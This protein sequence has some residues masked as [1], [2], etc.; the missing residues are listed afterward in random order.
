[1]RVSFIAVLSSAFI[2]SGAIGAPCPPHGLSRE[3][4]QAL[5]D[6]KF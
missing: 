1:M 6:N 3:S 5:K 4:L 2:A